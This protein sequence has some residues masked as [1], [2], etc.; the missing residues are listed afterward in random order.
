MKPMTEDDALKIV[1]R[2]GAASKAPD[3]EVVALAKSY[4]Q[5]LDML[6]RSR[7]QVREAARVL[8]RVP[9]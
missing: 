5:I 7:E 6:R 4:M 8:D 2:Y 3:P 1:G 9:T